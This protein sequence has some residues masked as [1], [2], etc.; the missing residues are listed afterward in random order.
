M[1]VEILGAILGA[2]GLVTG[3]LI[4]SIKTLVGSVDRME[5]KNRAFLENHMSKIVS[6]L[7]D[8]ADA[9]SGLKEAVREMRDELKETVHETIRTCKGPKT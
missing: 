4:W 7:C 9:A 5:D 6:A 2:F 8:G 1:S 3:G